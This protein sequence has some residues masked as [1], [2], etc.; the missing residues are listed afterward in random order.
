MRF[1]ARHGLYRKHREL[2]KILIRKINATCE[3]KLT[4]KR[5]FKHISNR[6]RAKNLRLL[7]LSA[8]LAYMNIF[9]N[10]AK[11]GGKR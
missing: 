11:E 2:T 10:K 6:D 1:N 4:P 3:V 8:A 5:K 7:R 9:S